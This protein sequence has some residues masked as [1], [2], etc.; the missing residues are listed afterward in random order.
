MSPSSYSR[1]S[2]LRLGSTAFL[3]SFAGCSVSAIGQDPGIAIGDIVLRHY[4]PDP[5]T[6]RLELERDGE[7]VT[8]VLHVDLAENQK[9]IVQATWPAAPAV[10]RLYTVVEG[11]LATTDDRFDVFVDEFTSEDD[12]SEGEEC[13]VIDVQIGAPPNSGDVAIGLKSPGPEGFGD[14]SN[15]PPTE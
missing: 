9:E 12:Q 13:S 11:P 7:I 15:A 5:H 2:V 4:P 1:R 10:Y 14:C 8:E 6:V 3:G